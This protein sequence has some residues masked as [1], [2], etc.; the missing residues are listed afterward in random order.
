MAARQSDR[1]AQP[2]G[3]EKDDGLGRRFEHAVAFTAI[4]DYAGELL[5]LRWSENVDFERNHLIVAE[6]LE[7]TK[8]PRLRFK[9]PKSDKVRLPVPWRRLSGSL[10]TYHAVTI[11]PD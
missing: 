7:A 6:S 11:R 1:S 8:T 10:E 2:E 9:A 5:A 3:N 4:T